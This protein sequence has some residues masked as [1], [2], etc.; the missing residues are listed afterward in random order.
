[1]PVQY[2][3]DAAVD[4]VDIEQEHVVCLRRAASIA[5]ILSQFGIVGLQP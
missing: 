1:M 4:C 5:G 3:G 2:D